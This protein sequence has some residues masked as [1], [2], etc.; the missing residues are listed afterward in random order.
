MTALKAVRTGRWKND[1]E[2]T[3]DERPPIEW[4]SRTW[5]P[6]GEFDLDGRTY[7]VRSNAPATRYELVDQL[8][9][10]EVAAAGRVGRKNWS[11]SSEGR[12]YDFQ[13]ASLWRLDEQL[14][15]DGRPAGGIRRSALHRDDAEAD[16]PG[17]PPHVQVFAL[18]VVLAGWD[19][20]AAA[21]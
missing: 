18:M 1:Y 16:L 14:I 7:S 20:A 8:T 19:Q 2:L 13:R 15:V 10:A 17:L 9:G 4:N 12:T 3:L 21:G 11:I 5:S 6:G